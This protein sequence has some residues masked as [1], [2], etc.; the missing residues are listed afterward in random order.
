MNIKKKKGAFV[1][2]MIKQSGLK[3]VSAVKM[4]E[5]FVVETIYGNT[6]GR[7]GDYKVKMETGEEFPV[8]KNVF[9]ECFE[10]K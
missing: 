3:P 5:D 10:E 1:P 6:H 2:Q 7:K 4:K 8:D 9:K